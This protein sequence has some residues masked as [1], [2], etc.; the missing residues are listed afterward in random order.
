MASGFDD[1]MNEKLASL[2]GTLA[3]FGCANCVFAGSLKAEG[4]TAAERATRWLAAHQGANGSWEPSKYPAITAMALAACETH[5]RNTG[6]SDVV[7]K[8]YEFLLSHVQ[9]DGGIY[10]GT[11]Y[12]NYNT[13]WALVSLAKR[14]STKDQAFIQ[15]ARPL[16]ISW[17]MDL[18]E[19]GTPDHPLD[20]GFG[21]GDG[22]PRANIANTLA[23]LAALYETRSWAGASEPNWNLAALLGFLHRSQNSTAVN[24]EPSV[25]EDAE[26]GGGFIYHPGKSFAGEVKLANGQTGFRSYG[27]MTYAGLLCYFYAGVEKKSPEV[28]AAFEWIERHFTVDENPGMEQQ[29]LFYYY[30]LMAKS[31]ASYRVGKI[32]GA[33]GKT[34]DWREALGR[35]LIALQKPDGSWVNPEGRWM[36]DNPVL[37]TAYSLMALGD[38]QR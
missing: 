17:Q 32:N 35:K 26:N 12:Q 18:G 9:P 27:S 30:H 20:G 23:P 14:H 6:K 36:E 8:A 15:K 28:Q 11:N 24:R 5:A 29:G 31:L 37:C 1:F 13:S 33:D 10:A 16:I 34:T 3:L 19:K 22:T 38:I 2:F 25:C 7:K 21:Y 4:A